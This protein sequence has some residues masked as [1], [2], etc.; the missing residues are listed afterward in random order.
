MEKM[1]VRSS[2]AVLL[3]MLRRLLA[4]ML[5]FVLPFALS[6]QD[7]KSEADMI[8]A[9][10]ELFEEKQY[11]K[12]MPLY[13]QLV[14]LY[15]KDGTYNMRYGVCLM[16][17][18][19]D[20][21]ASLKFLK[22]A[23]SKSESGPMAKFYFG[24]AL[25][26]NYD[27]SKAIRQY[28]KFKNEAGKKELEETQVDRQIQMCNNGKDLL[29]KVFE[30]NVIEKK[31]ISESEFFR[32]YDL[33][34]IG[35]KIIVKPDEFK[36]KLDLK[37]NDISLI[38]LPSDATVIYVSGYN[39]DKSRG[40]DIYRIRKTG[41]GWGEPEN[42][43]PTVNT[44]FDE[45]YP[46]MH[47]DGTL[48]FSSKGHNSMGGYDLFKS[49]YNESTG[50][51][52]KP[53]NLNFPVSSTFDD[54][55]FISDYQKQLAYFASSRN[56]IDG[57]LNVYR[58]QIARK[59]FDRAFL[60]GNFIAEGESTVNS[61]KITIYDL[62]DGQKVGTYF[63]DKNSG[64]YNISLPK[65]GKTYKFVVETDDNSPVH[66]GKVEVPVQTDMVSLKQEIRLV[67]EGD[68]QKLVIKNLFNESVPLDEDAM[69][70]ML[71]S[72]SNL[73]VNATE[74]D[75]MQD[76]ASAPPTQE[77]AQT[78]PVDA[79]VSEQHQT[80]Q[81]DMQSLVNDLQKDIDALR[82]QIAF[83]FK[84]SYE[85]AIKADQMYDQVEVNRQKMLNESEAAKKEKLVTQLMEQKN[86]LDPIASDAIVSYDFTK[87][88]ANE[89]DEKM[90]DIDRLKKD[91]SAMKES[92][93]DPQE[94]QTDLSTYGP[95]VQDIKSMRSSFD[96]APQ[97]YEDLLSKSREKLEME[98]TFYE[99][100]RQDMESIRLEIGRLEEE[101]KNARNK[102]TKEQLTAEKGTKEIDLEDLEYEFAN[103]SKKYKALKGEVKNLESDAKQINGFIAQVKANTKP[104]SQLSAEDQDEL[105]RI[106]DFLKEQRLIEDVIGDEIEA[107]M[108]ASVDDERLN[109]AQSYEPVDNSGNPVDYDELYMV[110]LAAI[111]LIQDES[112]R[113]KESSVLYENW[114]NTIKSDKEIKQNDLAYTEGKAEKDVLE[115]RIKLLEE[116]EREYRNMSVEYQEKAT[117]AEET[118]IASAEGTETASEGAEEVGKEIGEGKSA[119]KGKGGKTGTDAQ[120]PSISALMAST[121]AAAAI[122][123]ES[124]LD[125]INKTYEKAEKERASAE[126]DEGIAANVELAAFELSWAKSIDELIEQ[127]KKDL[128]DPSKKADWPKLQKLMDE[129]EAERQKH[130]A[131]AS[132]EFSAIEIDRQMGD[133]ASELSD[134]YYIAFDPNSPDFGN[135]NEEYQKLVEAVENHQIL[136]PD[137][138]NRE[139]ATIHNFWSMT[140]QDEILWQENEKGKLK[141]QAELIEIDNRIMDLDVEKKEHVKLSNEF[142]QKYKSSQLFTEELAQKQSADAEIGREG[143]VASI[144]KS[145]AQTF[146]EYATVYSNYKAEQ[147]A[148]MEKLESDKETVGSKGERQQIELSLALMQKE[149]EDREL[150][151]EELKTKGEGDLMSDE[152]QEYLQAENTVW[153]EEAEDYV[154]AKKDFAQNEPSD[155]QAAES[156]RDAKSAYDE[157]Q[158]LESMK[159]GIMTSSVV[160]KGAEA[161]VLELQEQ[162][163][164]KKIEAYEALAKANNVQYTSNKKEIER[165]MEASPDLEQ[166]NPKLYRDIQAADVIYDEVLKYQE[167]ARG[168]KSNTLKFDIYDQAQFMSEY[169][170]EEQQSI[171]A[172]LQ[173]EVYT[174]E[175]AFMAVGVDT[176]SPAMEKQLSEFRLNRR[177]MEAI[178]ENPIFQEYEKDQ[179]ALKELREERKVLEAEVQNQEASIQ[180]LADE[181]NMIV[182]TAA[183]QKKGK[184]KKLMK[185][186]EVIEAQMA[187][188][189]KKLDSLTQEMVG[190]KERENTIAS[191]SA[192]LL[193]SASVDDRYKIVMLAE[194]R[195]REAEV[196]TYL[197]EVEGPE[198]D[199]QTFESE[200][201][202]EG[203]EE[204]ASAD[205]PE[206]ETTESGFGAAVPLAGSQT[207]NNDE[208]RTLGT[209]IPE[210]LESDLFITSATAT[211]SPYNEN[212]P[213]PVDPV[214]PSGVIFK[215]QV[216]AYRNPIPQDL[217]K[218]FAPMTA[219]KLDNG[220]TRYSAG[221][222]RDFGNA[223]KAK[224]E[225]RK[226]GYTDAFV[227]AFVDGKRIS[228]Q[229]LQNV[230]DID[231]T[232]PTPLADNTINGV[233][234]EVLT[235]PSIIDDEGEISSAIAEQTTN[236]REVKGL[237]FAVQVGVYSNTLLPERLKPIRELNSEL[238]PNGNVRY[239]TGQF[240][241]LEEAQRRRDN[242]QGQVSDAFVT[243]YENGVRIGVGEALQ[244]QGVR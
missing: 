158:Y 53:E 219:E 232:P 34:E 48:Y 239:S 112:R 49:E 170:I 40:K 228:F 4:L 30:L 78:A 25:H 234:P 42:I 202:N 58:V 8:K 141:S 200:V 176:E 201:P 244:R 83:G 133:N 51:W 92:A 102:K 217:F 20:K 178:V 231:F 156:Y 111:E 33:G 223:N 159:A 113:Y 208:F 90:N 2:C 39:D 205:A 23:A 153:Q 222:F 224:A 12:A 166:S 65:G 61:A 139:L 3:K 79:S 77:A 192:R 184:R 16:H 11:A 109:T 64:K 142:Y 68:E 21:S 162:I 96:I 187:E 36:T 60:A 14:S 84:Y 94:M 99:E 103:I 174:G 73:E 209:E 28:E 81:S 59:P 143:P 216:G 185:E 116:K 169:V 241:T 69:T 182:K 37:S 105:N 225:I 7:Y 50:S 72:S 154:F 172:A 195:I 233:P 177:E 188:E 163:D 35:G 32:I 140:I 31:E 104:V 86:K 128:A 230:D 122:T 196:E 146:G 236:T 101:I 9:A 229:E 181:R 126:E 15:P 213:I 193:K 41:G 27:F 227:V 180:A 18:D 57:K 93:G 55:L 98:K 210:E 87:S 26:I 100:S 136:T 76:I 82:N 194:L 149:N 80:L 106:I 135:Y 198:R 19:P 179:V 220:I 22:Y 121:A 240:Q 173:G 1:D 138:K 161:E 211:V 212:K 221:L 120:A 29:K 186:A 52:S 168:F 107:F 71:Q 242:V 131:E 38:H 129:Y 85:N 24:R 150:A 108:T 175:L 238:L 43:G 66:T 199:V 144:D 237:F 115:E 123:S 157:V 132:K 137:E 44:E 56:T 204:V 206:T 197:S 70:A 167:N 47:P 124:T 152:A 134:K 6:A 151:E 45:D 91:M 10:E 215:V 110:N 218:G 164:A 127:T 54:V 74:E 226:M 191:N 189:Q 125:D 171:I 88:L 75:V 118:A 190:L 130:L 89:L 165:L 63:T 145:E 147:Q 207:L 235:T 243:A 183:G 13:S 203:G 119:S 160:N 148:R 97:R 117:Q 95:M 67:G 5:L 46:F 155:L 114:A 62:D 214:M 17:A